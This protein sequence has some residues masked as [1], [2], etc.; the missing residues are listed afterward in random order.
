MGHLK[1]CNLTAKP[2]PSNGSKN[3]ALTGELGFKT[4]RARSCF[5]RDSEPRK[6]NLEPIENENMTNEE[7]KNLLM[8]FN[9][10]CLVMKHR[11]LTEHEEMAMIE[12]EEKL[13]A[14]P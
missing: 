3:T 13:D 1:A 14:L 9:D 4:K 11:P 5:Q 8:R 7:I 6:L 2:M 12:I 10:L